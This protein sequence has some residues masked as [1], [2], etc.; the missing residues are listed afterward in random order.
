MS[1]YR[2]VNLAEYQRGTPNRP[3]DPRLMTTC[4]MRILQNQDSFRRLL[5]FYRAV[6]LQ[7]LH[8]S[9]RGWCRRPSR[10]EVFAAHFGSL[11]GHSD[12]FHNWDWHWRALRPLL[13][14]SYV[15]CRAISS[16]RIEVIWRMKGSLNV[17]CEAETE[18]TRLR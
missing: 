7:P 18:F 4:R 16:V 11:R 3:G 14:R 9:N 10:N 5:R 8:F 15:V 2:A 12:G 17:P 13:R 6:V 1:N